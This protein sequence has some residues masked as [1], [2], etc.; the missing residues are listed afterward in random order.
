[1]E[2]NSRPVSVFKQEKTNAACSLPL[3][4]TF[5]GAGGCRSARRQTC[6]KLALFL[7]CFRISGD[8]LVE[9]KVSEDG[10]FWSP[11]SVVSRLR[12][13][14]ALVV[15]QSHTSRLLL[16]SIRGWEGLF[17]SL[18]MNASGLFLFF[19]PPLRHW[20]AGCH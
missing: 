17:F 1:M 10:V 12:Y 19:P 13:A 2:R 7:N 8:A 14:L 6:T 18:L 15:W 20:V 16:V 4:R 9:G 5:W 3:V 11:V